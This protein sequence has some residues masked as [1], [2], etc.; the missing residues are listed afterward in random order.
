MNIDQVELIL[1]VDRRA[2]GEASG[3]KIQCDPASLVVNPNRECLFI[4]A[5]SEQS[6][7]KSDNYHGDN[8][9]IQRGTH[10]AQCS[11]NNVK[12]LFGSDVLN[13]RLI[14]ASAATFS[15]DNQFEIP[16]TGEKGFVV[17]AELDLSRARISGLNGNY[18]DD[19]LTLIAIE[20]LTGASQ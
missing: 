8:L 3:F 17:G 11:F 10:S 7:T 20:A 12:E 9:K 13:L 19:L 6:Q 15:S 5:I 2:E 1:L 14:D 4:G 18:S 16:R